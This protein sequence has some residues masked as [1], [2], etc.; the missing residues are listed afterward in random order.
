MLYEP[1]PPSKHSVKI[2]IGLALLTAVLGFIISLVFALKSDKSPELAKIDRHSAEQGRI[3]VTSPSS[4]KLTYKKPDFSHHKYLPY[5]APAQTYRAPAQPARQLSAIPRGI[6]PHAAKPSPAQPAPPRPDTQLLPSQ[7]PPPPPPRPRQ[8]RTHNFNAKTPHP[9]EPHPPEDPSGHYL[10]PRQGES[11]IRPRQATEPKTLTD[12][13]SRVHQLLFQPNEMRS[14]A[15]PYAWRSAPI[16]PIS[17]NKY[18]DTSLYVSSGRFEHFIP[19]SP[20]ETKKGDTLFFFR[21][22]RGTS[23]I[24]TETFDNG[25]FLFKSAGGHEYLPPSNEGHAL[26]NNYS[27]LAGIWIYAQRFKTYPGHNL[28]LA[29]GSAL[30]DSVPPAQ[31]QY[32]LDDTL[33]NYVNAKLEELSENIPPRSSMRLNTTIVPGVSIGNYY[34]GHNL[35]DIFPSQKDTRNGI[36]RIPSKEDKMTYY[37]FNRR[38]ICIET[39]SP[40]FYYKHLAPGRR[41]DNPNK[42]ALARALQGTRYITEDIKLMLIVGDGLEIEA[43][44][45]GKIVLMRVV[46]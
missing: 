29:A 27:E 14:A 25:T 11:M 41:W 2:G 7:P 10:P 8:G 15:F 37:F 40:Q 44:R 12:I 39:T 28:F 23:A 4:Q 9:S 45:N 6:N 33:E 13:A 38:L 32:Y 46:L 17:H 35:T 21:T 36:V 19:L 42:D 24:V 26:L 43:D 34:L 20:D 5:R 1:E 3:T 31:R 16:I 30:I 18:V 22:P